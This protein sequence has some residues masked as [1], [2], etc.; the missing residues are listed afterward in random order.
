MGGYAVEFPLLSALGLY[1]A[2]IRG[3]GN[4]LFNALS[5]QIYGNQ[6]RHH[7]IRSRVIE[8]MREHASYYK[9]FLDVHPGGGVRRNPKRKT[10]A[11]QSSPLNFERPAPEDVDRVFEQHLTTMA[12]GGTWGDN[13][14]IQAFSS[15]FNTDVKIYQ[16]DFAYMMAAADSR[17]LRPVAHIA[18]HSWE[19]YSSIRNLDGPHTG[20]PDV[21]VKALTPEEEAKQKKRLED[22]SP[23]QPWQVN[24]LINSLPYLVDKQFAKKVLEEN[25][26]DVNAACSQILDSEDGGSASSAQE[27]SSI[28]REPDSDDELL[29]APN[30][31]QDRRMSRNSRQKATPYDRTRLAPLPPTSDHGSQASADS[32]ESDAP[33]STNAS[34]HSQQ[35]PGCTVMDTIRVNSEQD[36]P[37]EPA[38]RQIRIKLN[39][40]KPPPNALPKSRQRQN[41]PRKP[42]ARD[43]KD[44]KKQAQKAARKERAQAAAGTSGGSGNMKTGMALR[45]KG[46]TETPP[47]ESGF[48]TL[49]I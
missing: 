21:Q 32:Q 26:G 12:R 14:E 40:P 20:L 33:S 31:K 6:D 1:A 41:G 2:D 8:Y 36:P 22:T 48:R 34:G 18:Y 28:E 45:S 23:V 17:E 3:D 5:D 9:Q 16:R 7:E 24:A 46:M 44:I 29:N 10:T 4:C 43:R 47:I 27:S 49:F 19:H 42:S 25:R 13:M 38:K 30:K 11:A 39:P 37:A 15:A 35:D